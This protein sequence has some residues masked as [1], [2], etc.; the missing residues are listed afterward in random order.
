MRPAAMVH[1]HCQRQQ[2]EQQQAQP[3]F[4]AREALPRR[5]LAAA[6]AAQCA[7]RGRPPARRPVL[8]LCSLWVQLVQHLAV[9]LPLI[10]TKGVANGEIATPIVQHLAVQGPQERWAALQMGSWSLALPHCRTRGCAAHSSA[11]EQA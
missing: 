2:L 7:G 4:E 3:L 8:R 1:L 6:G 9:H 5:R 11:A 10:V